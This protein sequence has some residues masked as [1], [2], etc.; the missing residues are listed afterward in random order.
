[1]TK[2][3]TIDYEGKQ[4]IW[5]GQIWY[6]AEDY[7]IPPKAII[8]ILNNKRPIH[9]K[10]FY[11]QSQEKKYEVEPIILTDSCILCNRPAPH[12]EVLCDGRIYHADCYS[13]LISIIERQRGELAELS[14]RLLEYKKT[15]KQATSWGYKIRA[16]FTGE[17]IDVEDC[18][19]AIASIKDKENTLRKEAE[20]INQRIIELWDY[21]PGYPPDW[22]ERRQSVRDDIGICERCGAAD[23]LQVHH[24]RSIS[25]G[26]NHCPENLEV[27]CAN[28]HGAIHGRDF[29]DREYRQ[30]TLP[31][32]HIRKM[33]ILR[34]VI[35]EGLII[36]FSYRKRD[37][38]RSKRSF[39]PQRFIS[40][41]NS[42]CIQGWCYLRKDRRTFA[43]NRMS[44]ITI[45]S[46]IGGSD[47]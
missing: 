20:G 44:H 32:A 6:G 45:D 5:N 14:V 24:R 8:D 11:P 39:K 18:K 7:L 1:M 43:I 33:E 42:V 21:W 10:P 2:L 16:F 34:N 17:K 41:G 29:I 15:I 30:T 36:H 3:V 19:R 9:Q 27:I 26:G 4:Y 35:E 31:S 38:E 40:Y 12:G 28:C 46:H 47:E 22:N 13:E 37:G 23:H 25:K